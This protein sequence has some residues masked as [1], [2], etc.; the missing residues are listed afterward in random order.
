LANICFA[1]NVAKVVIIRGS[2]T[3]ELKGIKK[4]L[5]K[6]DWVKQGTTVRTSKK[7]F[8][9]F[10]FVD[11][12]Q[13]NLGPESEMSIKTFEKDE[14][15]IINLIKGKVRAKV[16]KNYMDINKK[17]SKLFIKTKNAA[18]GVRGTELQ[19]IYNDKMNT[20]SLLTFEGAVAMAK[21]ENAIRNNSQGRLDEILSS[22]RAVIVREGEFSGTKPSSERVSPPVKIS[23]T[24]LEVLKGNEE[25]VMQQD[26]NKKGKSTT[27]SKVV[28]SVVPK[29]MDPKLLGS[30]KVDMKSEMGKV[31]GD[32]VSSSIVKQAN[33]EMAQK[34][35]AYASFGSGNESQVTAEQMGLRPGGVVDMA[36]GLY[37]NPSEKSYYDPNSGVY[38]MGAQDGT[39]DMGS[40]EFVVA[41]G[42]T[43]DSDGNIV[44]MTN[45]R[46]P[47]SIDGVAGT[48]GSGGTGT[49]L[50][51]TEAEMI[52]MEELGNEYMNEVHEKYNDLEQTN[53]FQQKSRLQLR[54]SIE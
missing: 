49:G 38:V 1:N 24:Q 21:I 50:P 22:D 34:K 11:K 53:I 3:S 43:V 13:M 32:K 48:D 6:G 17:K 30:Q 36:S 19:V 29:G 18:M 54:I 12:S 15:G 14:A 51:L 16:S 25:S 33:I 35:E 4:K 42:K 9:K 41:E 20:T 26:K 31:L 2:V 39:F 44:E 8:V 37:I 28:R 10:L 46:F 52:K 7:S 45:S 27:K 40:G 47:A 5:K 23:P